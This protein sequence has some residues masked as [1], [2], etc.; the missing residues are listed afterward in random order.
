MEIVGR[1]EFAGENGSVDGKI[2]KGIK[3]NTYLIM[4]DP[5]FLNLPF[6]TD[7]CPAAAKARFIDIFP[8]T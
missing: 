8:L 2:T 6:F 5:I 1:G 7:Y 4:P 3:T